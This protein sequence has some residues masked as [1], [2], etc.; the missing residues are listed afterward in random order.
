M[1]LG[2]THGTRV[3][4]RGG[5]WGRGVT[6]SSTNGREC[7]FMSMYY[8]D[9]FVCVRVC[10][11]I[12]THTYRVHTH[13]HTHVMTWS[14]STQRGGVPGVRIVKSKPSGA[15]V[16]IPHDMNEFVIVATTH[17]LRVCCSVLQCVAGCCSVFGG[18]DDEVEGIGCCR[19]HTP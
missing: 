12:H 16:N 9:I 19:Q 11:N 17:A 14:I 4:S 10:G 5:A 6:R 8:A 7:I 1:I 15:V 18:A 2:G 13:R 3:I